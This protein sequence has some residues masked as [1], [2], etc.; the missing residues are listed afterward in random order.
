MK[1]TIRKEY[2]RRTKKLNSLTEK[3]SNEKCLGSFPGNVYWIILRMDK[4][5]T[6]TNG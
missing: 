5:E 3:S 4:G 6:Q 2:H 1:E